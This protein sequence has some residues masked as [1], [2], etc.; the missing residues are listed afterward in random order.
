ME[1]SFFFIWNF[2]Y[3]HSNTVTGYQSALFYQFLHKNFLKNNEQFFFR[4]LHLIF[5]GQK[6]CPY[7]VKVTEC[8]TIRIN[9]YII[10]NIT[11]FVVNNIFLCSQVKK[12][13]HLI[14]TYIHTYIHVFDI[15]R[16]RKVSPL[17]NLDRR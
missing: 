4:N 14:H 10:D 12:W 7:Y 8:N 15:F 16:F 17:L 1:I 2:N 13:V 3:V 6:G 9:V 11:N 5:E